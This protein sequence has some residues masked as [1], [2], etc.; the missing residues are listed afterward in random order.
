VF[1]DSNLE[2][3][4]LHRM[5]A[6]IPRLQ[7]ALNFFA[8]QW[9]KFKMCKITNAEGHVWYTSVADWLYSVQSLLGS[10]QE[11]AAVEEIQQCNQG[12]LPPPHPWT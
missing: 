1:L 8:K 6:S 5:I 12:A 10:T 9:N 4:I 2:E 3:K 7:S 11:A